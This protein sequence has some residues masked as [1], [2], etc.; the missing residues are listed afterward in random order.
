MSI[1]IQKNRCNQLSIK[2]TVKF[3]HGKSERVLYR[4]WVER[5]IQ[6]VGLGD[7]VDKRTTWKLTFPVKAYT[8]ILREKMNTEQ[9]SLPIE[10]IVNLL[11]SLDQQA[12][13]AIFREVF[14][15]CDTTPLSMEEEEALNTAVNEYRKGET[16]SWSHTE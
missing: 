16:I 13:E 4:S 5:I 15:E 1:A 11:R 9:V 14:V 7:L 12:R 10:A 6:R 8:I 3:N 2:K